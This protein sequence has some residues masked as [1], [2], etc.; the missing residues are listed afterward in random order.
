MNADKAHKDIKQRYFC[1]FSSTTK[2]SIISNDYLLHLR[3][4]EG[5]LR[6]WEVKQLLILQLLLVEP[7]TFSSKI[8]TR[9]AS[10]LPKTTSSES[11]IDPTTINYTF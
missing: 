9:G 3:S 6:H 4:T 5:Q 1:Y 10:N 8:R 11:S 7:R 2:D